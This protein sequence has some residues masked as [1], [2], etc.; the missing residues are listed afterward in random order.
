MFPNSL[1][2][3]FVGRDGDPYWSDGIEWQQVKYDNRD[4]GFSA[5][6][7]GKVTSGLTNGNVYCFSEYDSTY[8]E[9]H[10][11]LN[12]RYQPPKK[13]SQFIN[14]LKE[15]FGCDVSIRSIPSGQKR[16]RYIVELCWGEEG[17]IARIYCTS[18]QIY[19]AAVEGDNLDLAPL[20]FDKIQITK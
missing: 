1:S 6:L 11:S 19:W 3:M 4:N 14:Q 20:F 13:E 16:V 8:Y 15:A 18:N 10:V 5:H 7:P 17:K 12:Q 2:A 9:V